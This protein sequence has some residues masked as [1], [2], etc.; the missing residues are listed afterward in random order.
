MG[1][2]AAA[3]KPSGSSTSTSGPATRAIC[4]ALCMAAAAKAWIL[5]KSTA[6]TDLQL[7]GVYL[8]IHR[9]IDLSEICCV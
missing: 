2:E 5:V 7:D 3:F 4:G 6:P 9:S 1:F 8:A